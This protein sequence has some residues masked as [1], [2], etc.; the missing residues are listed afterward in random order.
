MSKRFN[1]RRFVVGSAGLAAGAASIKQAVA[2]DH[3]RRT[4]VRNMHK[5]EDLRPEEFKAE[6]D[7]TPIVYWGC[8]LMEY[9]G[10][11]NALGIDSGKAYEICVRAV[12]ISGGIVSKI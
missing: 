5:Y 3:P 8:G 2:D 4:I 12:A 9:H 6:L 1:R 11:Y 10:L 7:R